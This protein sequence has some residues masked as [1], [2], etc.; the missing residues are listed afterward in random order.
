MMREISSRAQRGA[1]TIFVA[2]IMLLMITVLVLA[3]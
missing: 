2:M 1:V 3:A